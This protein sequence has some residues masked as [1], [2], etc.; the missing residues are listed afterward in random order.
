MRHTLSIVVADQPGELSRIVGLFSAR[1]FNIETVSVGQTPDPRW[2]RVTVVTRGDDGTIEQIVKQCERLARVREVQD[3]TNRPHIEREMALIDVEA[4][5]GAV[6]QEVLS[7]VSVFRGKVVD[8]SQTRMI[9]EASGN[10]EK[11]EAFIELL[12]PLGIRDITRTGLIAIGRLSTV[13]G[14]P[15]EGQTADEITSERGNELTTDEAPTSWAP[16]SASVQL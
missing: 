7:L 12:R 8:I 1:G 9:I 6:R 13:A 3:I 5:P 15:A 16:G 10:K 4:S 11:V 14:I 2:S